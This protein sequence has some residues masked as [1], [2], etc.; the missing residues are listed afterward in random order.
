MGAFL[1]D[2]RG[3]LIQVLGLLQFPAPALP[4]RLLALG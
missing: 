2:G 3:L 4:D 1:L